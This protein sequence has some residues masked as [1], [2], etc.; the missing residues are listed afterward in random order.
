MGMKCSENK[1]N[2][3]MDK[4]VLENK[5]RMWVVWV[6]VHSLWVGTMRII[7]VLG[8]MGGSLVLKGGVVMNT[9]CGRA[10]G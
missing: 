4:W 10:M 8:V 7:G 1:A 3:V 5:G 6:A 9:R 2:Q